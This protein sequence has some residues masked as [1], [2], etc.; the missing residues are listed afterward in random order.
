MYHAGW[1]NTYFPVNASSTV[2][3]SISRYEGFLKLAADPKYGPIGP[4][5]EIDLVWH[6]HQLTANYR[7][8]QTWQCFFCSLM[9]HFAFRTDTVRIV[10]IFMNHVDDS[11][12]EQLRKFAY[13]II[14]YPQ[15]THV[16]EESGER[17]QDAWQVCA[18]FIQRLFIIKIHALRDSKNLGRR[19]MHILKVQGSKSPPSNSLRAHA[20]ARSLVV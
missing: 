10:G 8:L 13:G 12:K 17:A 15:L 16:I 2:A 20:N 18:Q 3:E 7:Y 1:T 5:K 6:T 19:I 11:P 14:C 4:T 9:S